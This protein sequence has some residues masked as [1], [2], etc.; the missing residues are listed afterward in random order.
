[1]TFIGLEHELI[2]IINY[3]SGNIEA[4]RN[5]YAIS[6]IRTKVISQE[7]DFK[8]TTKLVLPGVGAFD[9]VM[10]KLRESN[11]LELLTKKVL[12]E[13]IPILGICVGLQIMYEYSDEGLEPG[14]SWLNGHVRKLNLQSHDLSVP[15]MGWNS[16]QFQEA[17]P[18]IFNINQNLNRFYFLHSYE[19]VPS[20]KSEV[21]G[22]SEYGVKIPS[23]I[24]KE[25]IFGTQFHPEKSHKTGRILLKNFGSI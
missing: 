21:I 12:I 24:A 2:G 8:Y 9:N 11:L 1:M 14:L 18:L 4:V 25:N 19:V 10:K 23:V 5:S 20:D 13:K 22:Y 7:N 3:G 6:N 15:H 17:H 16:V